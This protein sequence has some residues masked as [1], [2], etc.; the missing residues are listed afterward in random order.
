MWPLNQS[1][2]FVSLKG[3]N[4]ESQQQIASAFP[5]VRF[6]TRGKWHLVS[7]CSVWLFPDG[8]NEEKERNGKNDRREGKKTCNEL[9]RLKI[10]VQ[11]KHNDGILNYSQN[12]CKPKYAEQSDTLHMK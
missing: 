6:A 7:L 9:N 5:H 4:H 12:I 11:E 1:L 2:W 8:G 3:S 10:K